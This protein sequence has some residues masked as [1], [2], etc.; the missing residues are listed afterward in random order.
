MRAKGLGFPLSLKTYRQQTIRL[1]GSH[2]RLADEERPD[3]RH[4]SSDVHTAAF[5]DRDKHR[6]LPGKSPTRTLR[7]AQMVET[8]VLNAEI[9]SRGQRFATRHNP[10][11]RALARLPY[12]LFLGL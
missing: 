8:E 6:W 7:I 9:W 3:S 4:R 1:A 12:V 11:V 5:R 2:E 10:P